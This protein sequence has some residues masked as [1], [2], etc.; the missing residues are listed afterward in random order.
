MSIVCLC[1]EVFGGGFVHNMF[2]EI[3]ICLYPVN[4][5]ESICYCSITRVYPHDYA[6]H[7]RYFFISVQMTQIWKVTFGAKSCQKVSATQDN[8][9]IRLINI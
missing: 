7:A 9:Q 3:L 5:I 4:K 8:I 2:V 1:A 6:E